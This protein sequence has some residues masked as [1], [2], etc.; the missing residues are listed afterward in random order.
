MKY[1]SHLCNAQ[2]DDKHDL[3]FERYKFE[4]YGVYWWLCEHVGRRKKTANDNPEY[5]FNMGRRDTERGTSRKRIT[6]IIGFMHD[7]ELIRAEVRGQWISVKIPKL[8]AY[9]AEWQKRLAKQDSGATPETLVSNSGATPFTLGP[10]GVDVRERKKRSKTTPPAST[11]ESVEPSSGVEDPKAR[12][13]AMKVIK[14]TM[15]AMNIG[16]PQQQVPKVHDSG[17]GKIPTAEGSEAEAM[18]GQ[19]LGLEIAGLN[20]DPIIDAWWAYRQGTHNEYA[21]TAALDNQGIKGQDRSKIYR[22]LG[23]V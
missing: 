19:L 17:N 2:D 23:V 18:V 7:I 8:N 20:P 1:F 4:G 3:L 16:T 15:K 13:E 9:S 11:V 14:D 6:E 22:C 12:A 21:L 5:L 10:E